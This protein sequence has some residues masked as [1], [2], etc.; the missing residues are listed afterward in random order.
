[1]RGA[2]AA[3]ATVKTTTSTA[4]VET[5]ASSTAT[6]ETA[7]SSTA[8]V[9]TSATATT[10]VTAATVLRERSRRAEQRHGSECAK[11]NF[12]ERGLRHVH[13]LHQITS[14]VV[15]AAGSSGAILHQLDSRGARL[16]ATR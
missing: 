6:V 8:T 14:Q 12:K 15:Q 7:A 11:Y 13:Y 5:T 2:A 1:M 16:V 10:A 3:S 9:E 4:A